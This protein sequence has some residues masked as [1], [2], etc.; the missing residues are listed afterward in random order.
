[1]RVHLGE[2]VS[3]VAGITYRFPRPRPSAA[4]VT[5]AKRSADGEYG[6]QWRIYLL[7]WIVLFLPVKGT[8]CCTLA[9]CAE[10]VM[11]GG[12]FGT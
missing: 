11:A 10:H 12:Q 8:G 4:H 5:V 3:V 7:L 9:F 2:R 6:F 1:M